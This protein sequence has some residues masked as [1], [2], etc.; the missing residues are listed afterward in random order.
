MK[1]IDEKAPSK[2]K[3][4]KG[5]AQEKGRKNREKSA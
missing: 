5:G 2:E 1:I 3:E 4:K